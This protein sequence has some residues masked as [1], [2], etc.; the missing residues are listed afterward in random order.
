MMEVDAD[1][2]YTV[3][4]Q[5]GAQRRAVTLP[6]DAQPGQAAAA[7]GAKQEEVTSASRWSPLLRVASAVVSLAAV[8]I[9]VRGGVL[10]G[11]QYFPKLGG[12][13]GGSADEFPPAD[14][15]ARIRGSW[16]HWHAGSEMVSGEI[17]TEAEPGNRVREHLAGSFTLDGPRE[18]QWTVHTVKQPKYSLD[19][20][21]SFHA[22]G[23]DVHDPDWRVEIR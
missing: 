3:D 20:D 17:D 16:P 8:A 22:I 10:F 2:A 19:G 12:T 13:D 11:L 5:A 21:G 15:S 4:E 9:L 6:T 18:M 7:A 1:R 23:Y 14:A